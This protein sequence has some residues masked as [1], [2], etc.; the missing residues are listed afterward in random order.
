MIWEMNFADHPSHSVWLDET[1]EHYDT[2]TCPLDPEHLRTKRRFAV[3]AFA[4]APRPEP[5][6]RLA[7]VLYN[8][9]HAV[10]LLRETLVRRLEE[11]GATGFITAKAKVKLR[12]GTLLD[13]YHE[14]RATHLLGVATENSGANLSWVCRGCNL[15]NY[16]PGLRID[17]AV[18]E[19]SENHAADFNLIWPMSAAIF[20]SD[21]VKSIF[22]EFDSAEVQFEDPNTLIEPL[23]F[24]GDEDPMP[25]LS[26][27]ARARI[28]A[29]WARAPRWP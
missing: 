25:W 21:R 22:E 28:E 23:E 4:E 12:D 2:L 3:T 20:C 6:L 11:I 15:R 24:Y 1:V 10:F 26:P 7:D 9:N 8:A 18:A 19:M 29:Y 13:A 16:S 27:E 14:L 17:R 5:S